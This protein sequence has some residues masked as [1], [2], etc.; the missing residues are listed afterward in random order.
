MATPCPREQGGTH[1]RP[2]QLVH[3]DESSLDAR[4]GDGK[5]LAAHQHRQKGLRRV[6]RE[7]FGS[8]D[9][10][11]GDQDHRDRHGPGHDRSDDDRQHHGA[12][13][14][15]GHHDQPAVEA[16]GQGPATARTSAAEATEPE[17]PAPPRMR[18]QSGK[19]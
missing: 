19:Q 4:V 6:V 18:R 14:I 2:D 8:R 5:V 9:Q 13:R 7:Y 10:E 12:H 1:R 16:I 15:D 3:G 11:K 17:L